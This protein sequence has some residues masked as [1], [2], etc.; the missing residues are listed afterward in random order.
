MYYSVAQMDH[1]AAQMYL[2]S[3]I[4][5]ESIICCCLGSTF[6]YS[7]RCVN[8][9]LFSLGVTTQVIRIYYLDMNIQTVTQRLTQMVLCNK[10]LI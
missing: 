1:W 7:H 4:W 9:P 10:K 5:H 8:A 3:L 6:L 2:A